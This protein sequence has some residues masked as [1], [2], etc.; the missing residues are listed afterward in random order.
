MTTKDSESRRRF[1]SPYWDIAPEGYEQVS[2][3]QYKAM[4]ATGQVPQTVV[5]PSSQHLQGTFRLLNDANINTT[6]P[7]A[8]P[9]LPPDEEPK[10]RMLPLERKSPHQTIR[11]DDDSVRH[12]SRRDNSYKSSHHRHHSPSNNNDHHSSSRSSRHRSHRSGDIHRSS[13]YDDHDKGYRR[14]DSC[15]DRNHHRHSSPSRKKTTRV[16]NPLEVALKVA[17]EINQIL[18][19]KNSISQSNYSDALSPSNSVATRQARRLYVGNIPAGCTNEE[20]INFFETNMVA[21][22]FITQPGCPVLSCQINSDKNFA[23]VEFKTIEETSKATA[24]DGIQ[25]RGQALKIRRPHDYQPIEGSNPAVPP[26]GCQISNLLAAASTNVPMTDCDGRLV[27]DGVSSSVPDSPNKIYVG[28]LPN[29]LTD[30]QVRELLSSFGQLKN[31]NLVKDPSTGQSKGYAFCEYVDLTATDNAIMGLNGFPI[32]NKK[33]IVQRANVGTKSGEPSSAAAAAAAIASANMSAM[34][35]RHGYQAPVQIQVP[36][37]HHVNAPRV[38]SPIL[39]LMNMVEAEELRD[40]E[41]Y[42]EILEDIRNEC[43]KFGKVLSMEIPRPNQSNATDELAP[44]V[45]GLGKV[46]VEFDSPTE[47]QRAQQN[48]AGRRFSNRVVVTSFFDVDRYKNKEF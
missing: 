28:G 47:A 16:A 36:G 11:D 29:Y 1:K 15:N 41:E 7:L 12:E 21:C 40:D 34:S 4:Q 23:F 14:H 27:V 5:N 26:I 46:F 30:E 33:L 38:M 13:R 18:A 25:F 37:L 22:N 31:F 32:A 9:P 6:N 45:P 19:S 10:E 42:A 39:C 35:S 43:S 48:L 20:L 17:A 2:V 3:N 44:P 24:L 8:Q